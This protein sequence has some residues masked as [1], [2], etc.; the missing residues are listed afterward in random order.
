MALTASRLPVGPAQ[1][2][3]VT[4]QKGPSIEAWLIGVCNSCVPGRHTGVQA[5]PTTQGAVVSV[6]WWNPGKRVIIQVLIAGDG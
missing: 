3:L 4:G 5:L 1:Q 6:R 2:L